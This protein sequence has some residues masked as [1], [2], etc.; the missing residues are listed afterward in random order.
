[1]PQKR[2]GLI[3]HLA[4]VSLK[5]KS[6]V[7]LNYTEQNVL[8]DV[9]TEEKAGRV[10]FK[11]YDSVVPRV[12]SCH[13]CRAE[14]RWA[15][16]VDCCQFPR[17]LLRQGQSH[18]RLSTFNATCYNQ[19]LHCVKYRVGRLADDPIERK[20]RSSSQRFWI[21]RNCFPSNHSWIHGPGR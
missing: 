14:I 1:M 19:L 21:S 18:P 5:F 12:N 16:N 4:T 10:E 9:R 7:G 15:D 3:R 17:S 20:R 2:R 8:A 13:L 6:E 11:L